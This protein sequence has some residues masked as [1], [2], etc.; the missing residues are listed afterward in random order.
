[1]KKCMVEEEVCLFCF[2]WLFVSGQ[3]IE[4]R[5]KEDAV[6]TM[7]VILML[8]SGYLEQRLERVKRIMWVFT[9]VNLLIYLP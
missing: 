3:Q 8:W 2:S 5:H 9:K 1:M 4:G 6:A 7:P